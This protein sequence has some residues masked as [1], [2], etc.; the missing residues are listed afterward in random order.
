[1]NGLIKNTFKFFKFVFIYNIFTSF[2][3]HAGGDP[4]GASIGQASQAVTNW[5]VVLGSAVLTINLLLFAICQFMDWEWTRNIKPKVTKSLF[6][7]IF[8]YL[9]AQFFQGSV[10]SPLQQLQSC[11]AK[12]VGL[13]C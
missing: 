12:I 13:N 7:T 9:I 5:F 1:M 3:A 10:S 11:P 6:V 4:F 8:I 2:P